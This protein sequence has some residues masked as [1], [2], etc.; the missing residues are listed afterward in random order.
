MNFSDRLKQLRKEKGYTQSVVA[1]ALNYGYTAISNYESG[2]NQ[3]SIED[4][5][6]LSE[7]FQ[8]TVDYLIGISNNKERETKPEILWNIGDIIKIKKEEEEYPVQDISIIYSLK[9]EK[10]KIQYHF[11]EKISVS[12]PS[13]SNEKEE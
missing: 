4:L 13:E 12:V 10:Y 3:P 2:K 5:I 11:G 9:E 8:V 7:L 6:R 1:S